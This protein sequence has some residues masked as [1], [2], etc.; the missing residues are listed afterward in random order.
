[1]REQRS[2]SRLG[3]NIKYWLYGEEDRPVVVLTHGATL[4]HMSFMDQ[5]PAL[6]ENGYRVL[7][8]D[9]RGHGD[10]SP[11]GR[12]ATLQIHVE[13]LIAIMENAGIEKVT[14]VGHSL[15]GFVSQL[16]AHKYPERVD[17]L[18][19]LGCTDISQKPSLFYKGM[20]LIMPRIL[21]RMHLESFREKT[22]A[23]LSI[24]ETVKEYAREAM[25]HIPKDDFIKIIMSGVQALWTD[26]GIPEDYMIP[27]PFLLMHGDSDN[28]NGKVYQKESPEWEKRQPKCRYEIIPHAGHTAQMDNP[29]AF[30][31]VLIDFL[32][33]DVY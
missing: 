22:L 3:S 6:V 16:F 30:N 23:D 27:V 1:M 5:V 29:E 21:G 12:K 32:N 19:V 7:T 9:M 17:A 2:L 10:S 4:D 31:R 11:M 14:L 33:D 28:A 18:A 24:Y 25:D 8:W 13:D 15:G 26:S 20:Y